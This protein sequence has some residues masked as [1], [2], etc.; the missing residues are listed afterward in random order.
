MKVRSGSAGMLL[1]L[2]FIMEL[3]V[4]SGCKKKPVLPTLTTSPVSDIA[5]RTATTGGNISSDG[6]ADISARGVCWGTSSNPEITGS[7]T[8]DNK[9]PGAFTSNLSGLIPNTLYYV[10]AFASNEAGTAYGNEV[11]FSTNPVLAPVLT[12]AEI[13]GIEHNTAISGGNISSDGGDDVTSRGICWA[14]SVN[15]TVNDNKTTNGTGTG[16]FSAT[17]TGLTP[18]TTYHVRAW[19]TNSAGTS[20]GNDRSF[21]ALPLAPT[22]TTATIS[23]V[24]RTSAVSGGSITSDGGS[25]VT[26][27][28]ICWSTSP[29]PL[30]TGPHT[31]EGT[32][33]NPFVSQLTG[34][35]ANT[36]YYFRAYAT[37][38]AGT[39]YGNTRTFSTDP[40]IA[41][42]V[43]T[44]TVTSVTLTS[45]TGGGNVTSD[46]GGQVTERGFCWNTNGNPTTAD[47]KISGGTGTGVFTGNITGLTQGTVYYLKAY[48][49]NSAGTGYGEQTG[50]STSASD[51]DGNVYKTVIIGTQLWMQSDLKVTHLNTN[52]SIPDVMDDTTWVHYTEPAYC[53]YDDDPSNGATFGALYNY[54]SV[55]TGS[56]CPAGWHVP[57][58]NEFKTL[59]IYLGM[60]ESVVDLGG[61]RGTDQGTKLKST[62]TWLFDGVNTNSSGFT[63]LAG[64]Y[65]YGRDGGYNDKG[66]I[67]YWWSSTIHWSDTTRG[68]YR[69]LSRGETGVYRE[70]VIKS[71][72]KFVR[73]LKN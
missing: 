67:G 55:E 70:G 14:T 41:P 72:G 23:S 30:V 36:F 9:G 47:S 57:T 35:S 10:R 60:S 28:G 21:G 25:Q 34:L 7:H 39:S 1:A 33:S 32:G 17:L 19:A 49:I 48:A 3:L 73:C 51:I 37:N 8:S 26:A 2:F 54:Y 68:V 59:E 40:V 62:T 22:V 45:A 69:R 27:K 5:V 38:S 53:W 66:I 58:D 12:T 50:F 71:G 16:I 44:G 64:G 42:S 4:L 63:A 43:S 15:P 29:D 46:N 65:R 20:Y 24:T 61:W 11:T 52:Q 6:G 13:T 18:G 31:S 56:L